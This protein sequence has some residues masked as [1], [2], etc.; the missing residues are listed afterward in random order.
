MPSFGWGPLLLP[1]TLQ[2]LRQKSRYDLVFSL[3]Y[4]FVALATTF[5]GLGLTLRILRRLQTTPL[6]SFCAAATVT[7]LLLL[8]LALVSDLGSLIGI[9]RSRKFFL[10]SGYELFIWLALFQVF[11]PG[12]L[13]SGAFVAAMR[14]R[15]L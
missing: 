4:Y 7:L 11:L 10:H 12:S 6:R 1:D 13:L 9:W 8:S 3:P 15:K 2:Y 5:T 14:S